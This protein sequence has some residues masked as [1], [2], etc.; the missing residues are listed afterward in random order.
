L[1]HLEIT[2]SHPGHPKDVAFIPEMLIPHEIQ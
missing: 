2:V 1:A